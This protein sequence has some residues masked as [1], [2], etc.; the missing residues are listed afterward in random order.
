MNKLLV[1]DRDGVINFD[2]P[3]YIKSPEEWRAIPGSLEAIARATAAGWTIAVASNQ[4]A[5]GR[6]MIDEDILGL[7]HAKM[8]DEIEEAGGHI[9]L[10]TWCPH[11]PDDGCD[12]RKPRTGLL[13]RISSELAMPL[14]GATMVG[15][16]AKDL[17]A[18]RAAHMRAILVRTGNGARAE[19][20]N[21]GAADHV[22]DDLSAAIDWLLTES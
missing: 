1:L 16:S 15:D 6:G 19:I 8:A 11:H 14:E 9:T 10:I 5:I 2:S 18:A 12:C 21:P 20:E 4:S 17:E 13:E 7:I 22:A 3:D